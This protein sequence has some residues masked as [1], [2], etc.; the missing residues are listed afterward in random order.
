MPLAVV[1][2]IALFGLL[3]SALLISVFAQKLQLTR[4]EKYVH[5]FVSD[6]ELT[7]QR[8]EQAANVVKFAI[9]VWFLKRKNRFQSFQSLK[10]QRFVSQSINSLRRIKIERR[11]LNENCLGL[12]ELIHLQQFTCFKTKRMARE[13]T[14]IKATLETIEGNFIQINQTMTHLQA[15]LNHCLKKNIT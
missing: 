12:V 15:T 14:A 1:S 2:I 3:S 8:R 13:I 4:W 10:A 11:K 7:R 6:I 5:K 9:K